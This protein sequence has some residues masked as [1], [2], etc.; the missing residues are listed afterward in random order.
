[1]TTS[2]TSSGDSEISDARTTDQNS[3][4]TWITT[5]S[6]GH[7]FC[8]ACGRPGCRSDVGTIYMH[9]AGCAVLTATDDNDG[10]WQ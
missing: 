10:R 5:S 8:A 9:K 2:T 6:F 1:M 7:T 4:S 3:D